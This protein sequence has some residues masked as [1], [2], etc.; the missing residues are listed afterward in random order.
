M[1]RDYKVSLLRSDVSWQSSDHALPG[2]A[3]RRLFVT[4]A[5][6]ASH[7][8][9]VAIVACRF[10]ATIFYTELCGGLAIS[11]Q[12]CRGDGSGAACHRL[13]RRKEC[14]RRYRGKLC[15]GEVEAKM[16]QKKMVLCNFGHRILLP[17]AVQGWK[18]SRTGS[19][20]SMSKPL[21]ATAAAGRSGGEV[22][23]KKEAELVKTDWVMLYRQEPPWA[24]GVK[25][26]R[27]PPLQTRRSVSR[28]D[29]IKAFR[30]R[31]DDGGGSM[32]GQRSAGHG[33][34]QR[35]TRTHAHTHIHAIQSSGQ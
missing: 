31:E 34:N 4:H 22:S 26:F 29:S 3:D 28:S 27:R 6:A 32:D 7:R 10:A 17:G 16:G 23:H 11:G 15:Y 12:G 14:G 19:Q 25:G 9:L 21:L 1:A 35:D 8:F 24:A 13:F 5:A 2:E 33:A 18:R 20:Q 30:S